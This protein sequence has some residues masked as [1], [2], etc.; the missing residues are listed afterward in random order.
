MSPADCSPSRGLVPILALS[1]LL[2][3]VGC[4][5][6]AESPTSLQEPTAPALA[7]A[8]PQALSFRQLSAGY[9]HTCGVTSDNRAYCW[10]ANYD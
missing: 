2:A 6:D 7:T 1:L 8:S 3:V 4:G 5:E 9:R 10:G